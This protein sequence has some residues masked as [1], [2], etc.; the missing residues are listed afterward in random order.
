[1]AHNQ[2]HQR[3][4]RY[5]GQRWSC[6]R[7]KGERAPSR[8]N[9]EFASQ[10]SSLGRSGTSTFDGLTPVDTRIVVRI[11]LFS[12]RSYRLVPS[13]LVLTNFDRKNQFF[14]LTFTEAEKKDLLYNGFD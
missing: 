14:P 8:L 5:S 10:C 6:A 12:L 3:E 2:V 4:I 1:M 9:L 7:S 13:K 11:T